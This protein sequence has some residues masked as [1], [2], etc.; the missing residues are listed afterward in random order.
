MIEEKAVFIDTV[1]WIAL[2]HRGNS[3]HQKAIQSYRNIKGLRRI[4]TDA[5]LI[6]SC[7][8]FSKLSMRPLAL[9]LINKVDESKTLGILEV[10]HV[11]EEFM[12]QGL[13][14]F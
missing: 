7:N 11:G 4:T 12:R 2:I 14:F 8:A 6:E 10:I 5:V 1:G 13:D 3:L 9:A